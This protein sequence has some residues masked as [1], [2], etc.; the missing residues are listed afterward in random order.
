MKRKKWN[1]KGMIANIIFFIFLIAIYVAINSSPIKLV[2]DIEII[3]ILLMIS[4]IGGYLYYN[5]KKQKEIFDMK[6]ILEE[7]QKIKTYYPDE[8]E[9][10]GFQWD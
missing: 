6:K 1:K 10:K 4:A 9:N 7:D 2:G 8:L 3:M 5:D